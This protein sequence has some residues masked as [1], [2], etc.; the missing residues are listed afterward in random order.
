MTRNHA[1]HAGLFV[2]Y[3]FPQNTHV[4]APLQCRQGRLIP[5]GFKKLQHPIYHPG[6]QKQGQAGPRNK[7]S[8][9]N[10]SKKSAHLNL[11]IDGTKN[12]SANLTHTSA[13]RWNRKSNQPHMFQEDIVLSFELKKN[14]AVTLPL[15]R[16]AL[17]P[18]FNQRA[19]HSHVSPRLLY[20]HEC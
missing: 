18:L 8:W 15:Q 10:N 11:T 5:G 9:W 20:P 1:V 16:P 13:L 4:P 2:I 17:M 19:L 7:W 14:W 6:A 3:Y 12:H